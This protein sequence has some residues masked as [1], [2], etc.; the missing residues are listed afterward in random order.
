LHFLTQ[1]F[2]GSPAASGTPQKTSSGR[3]RRRSGGARSRRRRA[4]LALAERAAP[5]L[6]ARAAVRMLMTLPRAV[7]GRRPAAVPDGA[8]HRGNLPGPGPSSIVTEAWG[9]GPAVY[10]LHGWGGDR[11]SW[12][13]FVGPLT[14]AG[15]RAV[16]LDAPGHG[17]SGPGAYGPGRTLLP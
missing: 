6:G 7:P 8:R 11:T 13:R 3:S 5:G 17:D 4:A 12:H 14:R 1:R 10:L 16:T 15:F 9:E 2:A